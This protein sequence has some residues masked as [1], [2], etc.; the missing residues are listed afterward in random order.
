MSADTKLFHLSAATM[1]SNKTIFKEKRQKEET[2]PAMFCPCLTGYDENTWPPLA[3]REVGKESTQ[4]SGTCSGG[5]KRKSSCTWWV[6]YQKRYKT[7]QKQVLPQLLPQKRK[8]KETRKR[9]LNYSAFSSGNNR[10]LQW[11][12]QYYKIVE[13]FVE[14]WLHNLGWLVFKRVNCDGTVLSLPEISRPRLNLVWSS[15][16]W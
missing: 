7:K 9:L 14:F 8:K 6:G 2:V 13:Q 1:P 10:V 5:A 3:A 15:I 12:W 11:V 4:F 16:L